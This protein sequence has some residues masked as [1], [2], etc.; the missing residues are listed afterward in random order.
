LTQEEK[1]KRRLVNSTQQEV[2]HTA[3]SSEKTGRAHARAGIYAEK[4]SGSWL[5]G[6]KFL[7]CFAVSLTDYKIALRFLFL[8]T[9]KS[10]TTAARGGAPASY[11]AG[12]LG[13]GLTPFFG[14]N[15]IHAPTIDSPKLIAQM[16][17]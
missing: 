4:T 3:Q 14:R 12:Q 16:V 10:S 2:A 7:Y 15:R 9:V 6:D 5:S 13:K 17:N 1:E 8:R 11:Q